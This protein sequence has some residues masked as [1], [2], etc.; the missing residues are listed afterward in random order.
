MPLTKYTKWD[1]VDWESLSLEDL[2]ERLADFLLQSG[3]ER[4]YSRYWGDEQE[5]TMEAL[6]DAIMRALMEG[7]LSDEELEELSD[8]RG[9]LNEKAVTE[10]L[11]RLIERLLEEGYISL[12]EGPSHE[13]Q[14][15]GFA[16]QAGRT[17]KP[18][19]HSVKFEMTDKGLDFLGFKALKE[20]ISSLGKASLGRHETNR[21]STG[22]EASEAP[23][24]EAGD[25]TP[26]QAAGGFAVTPTA[27]ATATGPRL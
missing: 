10:L 24:E 22:V 19:E 12:S 27:H 8:D 21:L 6:R 25:S 14:D 2:L 9:E 3:Y 4:Q 23:K 26:G 11:D 13:K 17:G 20:L 18:V 16:S 5:R 1:G 15:S 7:L